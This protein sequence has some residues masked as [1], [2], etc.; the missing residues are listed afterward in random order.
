M[1]IAIKPSVDYVV[2]LPG[3]DPDVIVRASACAA[4]YYATLDVSILDIGPTATAFTLRPVTRRALARLMGQHRISPA[5]AD[6]AGTDVEAQAV[7]R[8]MDFFHDLGLACLV[9]CGDIA[10]ADLPEAVVIALGRVAMN[11]AKLSAA[12]LGN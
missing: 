2:Y 7:A 12:D 10:T 6:L 8:M 11:Q 9:G 5:L 3:F 4:D 1:A